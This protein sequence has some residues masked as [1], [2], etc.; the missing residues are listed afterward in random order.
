MIEELL[1]WAQ[2]L[3]QSDLQNRLLAQSQS[4][5]I[6]IAYIFTI[7]KSYLFGVAFLFCESTA[8]LN[9]VPITLT[10]PIYGLVFYCA[11][12]L[13]W[14]SV[15]GLHIRLTQNKNTLIACAI[16]LLFLLVMAVDSYVNAYNQTFIHIYYEDIIL[17]IH[18]GIIVSLYRSNDAIDRL[19]GEFSHLRDILCH[20]VYCSY[21]CYTVRKIN[22]G[23]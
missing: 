8:M 16:M 10:P 4:N 13:T 12:L 17:C 11:I 21:F 7:I 2:L 23:L 6:F 20:N 9:F 14:I 5:L 15:A 3:N 19:V 18:V 22:Q 1:T